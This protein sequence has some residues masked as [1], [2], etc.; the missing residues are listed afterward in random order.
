M[1]MLLTPDFWLGLV[2]IVWINT[3]LSGDN[4]VVI[5]L[6]ARTL[7]PHH[8]K[9]AVLWG[10][11]A[12]VILLVIFT[13]GAAK[14]MELPYVQLVGGLMLLWIGAKLLA[15]DD[16]QEGEF[17]HH[18]TLMSA[19]R[20]I[21]VADL[22]MS[23]DNVIAVAAAAQG[24][25]TLLILGLGIS[26]P[27]VIFGATLMVRVMERYPLLAVAGA[28]LI[29]WVA[30]ETVVSDSAVASVIG[31]MHWVHYAAAV[32]GAV[33]V[34]LLGKVMQMRNSAQAA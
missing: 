6:A 24:S 7:P 26:I 9:L 30:G 8:Q 13:I 12:A 32:I 33:L 21:L 3:I 22:I 16:E 10:S 18:G 14:L 28:C 2:K 27:V 17:K 5:A 34:L 29:G 19:I 23:L 25:L 11:A 1:E 4:A 31:P 15:D 20:T